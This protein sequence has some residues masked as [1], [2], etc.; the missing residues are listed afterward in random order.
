MQHIFPLTEHVSNVDMRRPIDKVTFSKETT[1]VTSTPPSLSSTSID[2]P[3]SKSTP[4]SA[5]EMKI[6]AS[7]V[8][9]MP[10][11]SIPNGSSSPL[12]QVAE[13]KTG[14]SSP[15]L[16]QV[17]EKK[18]TVP[19][20]MSNGSL[21]PPQSVAAPCIQGTKAVERIHINGQLMPPAL[22]LVNPPYMPKL[23]PLPPSP[24]SLKQRQQV[25]RTQQQRLL[26]LRHASK[27][28]HPVGTCTT[29]PHCGSMK[30]LGYHIASCSEQ[31]CSTPHCISS[32]HLLSHYHKCANPR[33]E[34]CASV[35]DAITKA[36]LKARKTKD[37]LDTANALPI[38]QLIHQTHLLKTA[39]QWALNNV[40][41]SMQHYQMA[42][43]RV[44][45]S[46]EN[47][48]QREIT[49]AYQCKERVIAFKQQA[50]HYQ[51]QFQ[52]FFHVVRAKEVAEATKAQQVKQSHVDSMRTMQ[53]QIQMQRQAQLQGM[54]DAD[55]L[56]HP[57]TLITATARNTALAAC[58]RSRTQQ[59][60]LH[61]Q[62][63]E[64][65]KLK[66]KKRPTTSENVSQIMSS[67]PALLNARLTSEE[68]MVLATPHDQPLWVS[69]NASKDVPSS[70]AG[71]SRYEP[72]SVLE[73]LMTTAS[74]N[75]PG[76]SKNQV[77]KPLAFRV[78]FESKTTLVKSA[79]VAYQGI[80][81]ALSK[82]YNFSEQVYEVVLP[83]PDVATPCEPYFFQMTTTEGDTY[84]LPESPQLLF[85]NL[86]ELETSSP[87]TT[88]LSVRSRRS[89][90]FAWQS[91]SS[92]E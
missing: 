27:C 68:E 71:C 25:L 78:F 82:L 8:L 73:S 12:I 52:A 13:Q 43:L 63:K 67:S 57:T 88:T 34:I 16:M 29:T 19:P 4:H 66:H 91:S 87:K 83:F 89:H 5:L 70:S 54:S 10:R 31:Q 23:L 30:I 15:P 22:N 41:R 21:P 7:M 85:W 51:M 76:S 49:E 86:N 84:R 65:F 6:S 1:T 47:I 92:R 56:P 53:Q 45:S 32:R 2:P 46:S 90:Y 28:I 14:I 26:L 38:P 37:I 48:K 75:A 24:A 69:Q 40:Q 20:S 77:V 17:V 62:N 74:H 9:E 61:T 35:R 81:H 55:Q 59:H 50:A 60:A 80:W 36:Q 79:Y 3:L 33:C 44:N 39:T 11:P 64:P 72:R 42:V 58:A 18:T